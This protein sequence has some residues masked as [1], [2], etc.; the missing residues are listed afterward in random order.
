M[1]DFNERI[2][3]FKVITLGLSGVGKTCLLNGYNGKTYFD[4]IYSTISSNYFIKKIKFEELDYN[5]Q[6]WDTPGRE[7]FFNLLKLFVKNSHI[8]IL[9]FDMTNKESF[10]YLDKILE[11]IELQMGLNKSM[12]V[13][14]GNKA[15]RFEEWEIRESDA[16][17]FAN[18]LHA[19]FF[20]SSAKNDP[21]LF[22][23]FLDGV[24]QDFI[25]IYNKNVDPIDRGR[26]RTIILN[27][28]NRNNRQNRRRDRC[29]D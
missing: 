9:V 18:I 15:D 4:D 26:Q 3:N 14:I 1:V 10:L 2:E 12:F 5:M 17:E 8:I 16:K 19:K 11:M 27:R 20:L 28:G 13:L 22:Q 23:D 29:C 21:D 25:K 6:I 24:F 7:V